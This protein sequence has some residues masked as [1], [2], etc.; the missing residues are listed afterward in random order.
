MPR[1]SMKKNKEKYP[2]DRPHNTH[3]RQP[4]AKDSNLAVDHFWDMPGLGKPKSDKKNDEGRPKLASFRQRKCK[5]EVEVRREEGSRPPEILP[6]YCPCM[7]TLHV[8]V[9]I[10]PC[11]TCGKIICEKEN[12]GN[13]DVNDYS[14]CTFCGCYLKQSGD[15]KPDRSTQGGIVFF[16]HEKELQTVV[17]LVC[18]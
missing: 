2:T 11:L 6:D 3:N 12:G 13:I 14:V 1:K 8:P 15:L 5:T 10:N 18:G 7:G 17:P 4:N 16:I 9:S